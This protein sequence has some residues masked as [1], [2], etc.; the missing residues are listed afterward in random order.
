MATTNLN[1]RID[2]DLKEQAEQILNELGLN[3]TT[4]INVFLRTAV[5]EHGIPFSLKPDISDK[6]AVPDKTVVSDETAI[7]AVKEERK[8]ATDD[9]IK[10]YIDINSLRKAFEA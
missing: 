6:T 2:R 3:M 10:G 9:N 1:I 8:F 4:T 5:R 7:A